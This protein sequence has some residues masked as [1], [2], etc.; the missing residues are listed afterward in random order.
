[1]ESRAK[2]FG[3]SIHQMLIVFPLIP[4]VGI[5]PGANLDALSSLSNLPARGA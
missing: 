3:H 1:M 2:L 5:D 4:G